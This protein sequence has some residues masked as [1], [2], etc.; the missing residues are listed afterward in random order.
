MSQEI[1]L[2]VRDMARNFSNEIIYSPNSPDHCHLS[3]FPKLLHYK[4]RYRFELSDREELYNEKVVNNRTIIHYKEPHDSF[5]DH[6]NN[7]FFNISSLFDVE[8][9]INAMEDVFTE[10]NLGILDRELVS[11]MHKLWWSRQHAQ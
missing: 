1:Q 7:K 9:F 10:W 2:Q 5:N 6:V 3:T 4:P 11:A 8:T